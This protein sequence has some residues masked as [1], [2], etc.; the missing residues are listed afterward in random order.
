MRFP[1]WDLASGWGFLSK[2]APGLDA[3]GLIHVLMAFVVSPSLA[4]RRI[5]V[6]GV[7]NDD[8]R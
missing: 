6:P 3:V 2:G 4:R 1:P 8:N 5:Y 7:P